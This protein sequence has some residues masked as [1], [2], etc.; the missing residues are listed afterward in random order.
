MLGRIQRNIIIILLIYGIKY[1]LRKKHVKLSS[2]IA[3]K[4]PF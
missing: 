4:L 2:N 3:V 1:L